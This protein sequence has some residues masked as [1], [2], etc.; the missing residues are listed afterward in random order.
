MNLVILP[1]PTRAAIQPPRP[2][3]ARIHEAERRRHLR[4]RLELVS[5]TLA[6]VAWDLRLLRKAATEAACLIE[7][8][9]EALQDPTL[10]ELVQEYEQA[11]DLLLACRQRSR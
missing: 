1:V 10:A 11:L 4:D 5:R 7:A 2:A 6:I 9:V 3:V 8:D